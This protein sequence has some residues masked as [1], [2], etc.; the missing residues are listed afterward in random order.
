MPS[1][2]PGQPLARSYYPPT[3][4]SEFYREEFLK[5]REFLLLQ[6]EA[7]SECTVQRADAALC[8]VLGQLDSLCTCQRGVQV[9]SRLLRSFDVVTRVSVSYDRTNAH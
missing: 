4:L 2:Q 3:Q 8:R 7:F 5:Q 6:R 1:A 9:V